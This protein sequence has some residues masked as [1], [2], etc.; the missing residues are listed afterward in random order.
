MP[1]IIQS[2]LLFASG[3]LHITLE[4]CLANGMGTHLMLLILWSH[5][6]RRCCMDHC[7]GGFREVVLAATA[8]TAAMLL[9]LLQPQHAVG[10]ATVVNSVLSGLSIKRKGSIP[11]SGKPESNCQRSA[12]C[13][14][15]ESHNR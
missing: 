10:T 15:E 11:Q 12:G 9:L 8:D 14:Q 2:T 3:S 13:L 5:Q 6:Q 1:N 4:I 7:C